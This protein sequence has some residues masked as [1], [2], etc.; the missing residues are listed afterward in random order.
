M[1]TT[2]IAEFNEMTVKYHINPETGNVSQCRA[3][4]NCRFAEYGEKFPHFTTKEEAQKVYENFMEDAHD[5]FVAA[6][7]KTPHAIAMEL[8]VFQRR[9]FTH[10]LKKDYEKQKVNI[11]EEFYGLS[12]NSLE[13][14]A[15]NIDYKK[16]ADKTSDEEKQAIYDYTGL[17]YVLINRFLNAG[18]PEG[19]MF[20]EDEETNKKIKKK[21]KKNI[22]LI[23]SYISQAEQKERTLFRVLEQ[24]PESVWTSSEDYLKNMGY[25]EGKTLSFKGFSSCTIDPACAANRARGENEHTATTLVIKTKEGAPVDETL[26]N[27]FHNG[28]IQS[29]EREVLLPRNVQF[30]ISKI[31]RS[32]FYDTEG[33]TVEPLT[34]FLEEVSE[35]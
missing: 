7:R 26:E 24:D 1:D 13:L 4:I 15:Y 6:M 10:Q 25:A 8:S 20:N 2:K 14:Q 16:I 5:P 3:K 33:N 30:K 17:D 21:L 18:S 19:H 22:S 32:R 27:G 12:E 34:V 35:E 11:T 31:E 28:H 23:D 9:N 29:L